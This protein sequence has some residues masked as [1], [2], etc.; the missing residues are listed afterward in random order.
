MRNLM[1]YVDQII[2]RKN[3]GWPG[4]V[5]ERSKNDIPTLL[6]RIDELETALVPFARSLLT[7]ARTNPNAKTSLIPVYRTDCIVAQEVIDITNAADLPRSPDE[8]LLP[9]E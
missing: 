8:R 5:D 1:K 6:K 2:Q 9:A 4:G 3:K 7:E